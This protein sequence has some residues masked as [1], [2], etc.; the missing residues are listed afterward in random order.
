MSDIGLDW[1]P[2]DIAMIALIISAPGLTGGAAIGA[3]V[4]HRSVYLARFSARS[5]AWFNGSADLSSGK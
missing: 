4:L 3:F 2:L 1:G 5:P